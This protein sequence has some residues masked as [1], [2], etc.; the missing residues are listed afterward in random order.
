MHTKKY[1]TVAL[2][3]D[4]ADELFAGYNKHAAELKARQGGI[5]ASMVRSAHSLLKHLPKSRNSKQEI[6]FANSKNLP[7]E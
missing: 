6:K 7:K 5:K 4:G 1:V 2:S 3:G